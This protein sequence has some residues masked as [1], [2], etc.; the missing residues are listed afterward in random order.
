MIMIILTV[1][2][3]DPVKADNNG[4]NNEYLLMMIII[5]ILNGPDPV[6]ANNDNDD[7]NDN[8]NDK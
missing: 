8:N 2:G 7:T 4:N 1:N 3:P 5:M 6:K